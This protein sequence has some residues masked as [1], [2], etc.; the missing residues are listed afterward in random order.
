MLLLLRS[1]LNVLTGGGSTVVGRVTACTA[2]GLVTTAQAT[3]KVETATVRG[4]VR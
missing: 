1:V 4:V 2:T 3:A